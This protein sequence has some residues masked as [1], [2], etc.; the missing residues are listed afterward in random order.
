[1][2]L[3]EM[4]NFNEIK[5]VTYTVTSQSTPAQTDSHLMYPKNPVT[6]CHDVHMLNLLALLCCSTASGAC[7]KMNTKKTER[8]LPFRLPQRPL[9]N[10]I[11]LSHPLCK[12]RNTCIIILLHNSMFYI[13]CKTL[14][15]CITL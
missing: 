4:H 6:T 15:V 5:L 7:L 10:L 1:M 14:K 8:V 13:I 11:H 3:L 2:Q 9:C 12:K